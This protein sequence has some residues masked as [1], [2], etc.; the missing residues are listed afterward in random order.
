MRLSLQK[1]ALMPTNTI[2]PKVFL[3]AIFLI[4][5][6]LLAGLT[7]LQAQRAL[8][9]KRKTPPCLQRDFVV[10]AHLVRDTF[11]NINSSPENIAAALDMVNEWFDPICVRF[12][13]RQVDTLDNFQYDIPQ[14]FNELDQLWA[15][16]NED[17]FIN[18]YIVGDVSFVSPEPV[19]A[20]YEGILENERGGLLINFEQLNSSPLWLVHGFGHY[21]G[22]LDTNEDFAEQ[23]VN[24]AN[25][26][27]TG[28]EVCDTPADPY[29]ENDPN[30][31]LEVYINPTCRFIFTGLDENGEFYLT[32]TG[33]AMS[34]YPLDCWCG[35]TF[36]QFERM[37]GVI[38]RSGLW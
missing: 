6:F 35:L 22:L 8:L 2:L 34:R 31:G 28:D 7:P 24:G 26:E 18:L 12:V 1:R 32:Q 21:C 16:H 4:A 36:G 17:N 25:C 33:N 27:T 9:D 20:T 5:C 30:I 13:L 11:Q 19:F 29:N 3:P 23:L 14:N 38:R 10:M 15:H 37:A